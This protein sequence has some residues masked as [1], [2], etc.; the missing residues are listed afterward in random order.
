MIEQINNSHSFYLCPTILSITTYASSHISI[1]DIPVILDLICEN[2]TKDDL[3]P[4]LQVSRDWFSLFLPQVLR[5]VEFVNLKKHHTW[6]ILDS[7]P[8]IWSLTIDISDAG[9][10]VNNPIS[11]CTNLRELH[12]VDY[13]YL[14]KPLKDYSIRGCPLIV[15]QTENALLLVKTNPMLHT[16]TVN[17]QERKY[18]DNHITESVLESLVSHKSLARI[19]I[20]IPALVS[21][22]RFKLYN[23]FLSAFGTLNSAMIP[24]MS[25][26]VIATSLGP[27][28]PNSQQLYS[29]SWNDFVSEDPGKDSQLTSYRSPDDD[30]DEDS[31]Y[32]DRIIQYYD[33]EA[34]TLIQRSPQ[35][36][37]LVLRDHSGKLKELMQLLVTSCLDLE[38]VDLSTKEVVTQDGD[39]TDT[40]GMGPMPARSQFSKLR[41]FRIE[42]RWSPSTY[43]T[44]AELISRSTATLEV[45]WFNRCSWH[46]VT[47]IANPFHI[48]TE[49]SWARCTQLKELVLYQEKEC[50]RT[51]FSWNTCNTTL[52]AFAINAS[53][54][55]TVFSC[56]ERLKLVV[57]VPC[58]LECHSCRSERGHRTPISPRRTTAPSR[59]ATASERERERE[60]R[61]A[62]VLQAREF[63]GRIKDLKRLRDLKIEWYACSI[64]QG[65]NLEDALQLFYE[66]EFDEDEAKGQNNGQQQKPSV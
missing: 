6:T 8:R 38:T 47:N 51:N 53:S 16:L 44:I 58:L 9:C 64:I 2:F 48:D 37:D 23:N 21:D 28:C 22:V 52:A 3:L 50:C 11:P 36:R 61:L 18:R 25:T 24:H 59:C 63:Y 27:A 13:D 14:P 31:E 60:N 32:Y 33:W 39:N 57:G 26:G 40:T 15:D 62:F 17:H 54:A 4:C 66:T 65:M 7:A 35:L 45:A 34:T 10:F 49:I 5:R 29:L 19:H 42:G 41:E 30:Y 56:L 43:Q 1:F 20:S 55:A 46:P 12:C